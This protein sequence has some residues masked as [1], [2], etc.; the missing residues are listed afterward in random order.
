MKT[1]LKHT[2]IKNF[3]LKVIRKLA[4]LGGYHQRINRLEI[5]QKLLI[6]LL[7]KD[8]L[9]MIKDRIFDS[10]QVMNVSDK[11]L[12]RVGSEFD[13]GYVIVDNLDDVEIVISIGIG[14]NLDKE[15]YFL[16]KGL[17]VYAFDGTIGTSTKINHA[18]FYFYPI[19]IGSKK[20]FWTLSHIFENI[21]N[22]ENLTGKILLFI[23]T[24]GAE[25]D[26]LD[27]IDHKYFGFIDQ[28]IVEFHDL[29]SDSLEAGAFA[30]I[31]NSLLKDFMVTHVHGNNF[32]AYLPISNEEVIPD[33]IEI[34]F[35]NKRLYTFVAGHNCAPKTIDKP[36]NPLI[37]DLK[38]SWNSR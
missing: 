19:N 27:S 15:K 28:L 33:V 3:F 2:Q 11:P 38:F 5:L 16:S 26:I 21:I 36:C 13:G 10:L 7:D 30:Q 35:I 31:T 8:K 17:T 1:L 32:G 20:D 9:I 12:V 4:F 22:T 34:S 29:I 14:N 6:N 23:D 24:E 25:Y 37:A 18:N